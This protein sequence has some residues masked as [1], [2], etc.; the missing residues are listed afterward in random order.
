[1]KKKAQPSSA[2]MAASTDPV[3]GSSRTP[4]DVV[5]ESGWDEIKLPYFIGSGRTLASGV[6]GRLRIKFF[7]RRSDQHLV[8][9]VWFGDGADGPP[10]HAHGGAVAYVLDEAMGAVGWSVGYA[11][12]ASDLRFQYMAM[13]PLYQDL[14]VEAWVEADKGKQIEIRSNLFLADGTLA[15][16]GTGHFHKLS[17]KKL[18]GF[19]QSLP[20]DERA[21]HEPLM[22]RCLEKKP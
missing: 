6:E 8:G 1:M 20:P 9:R 2:S 16:S 7:F 17:P 14:A 21:L 18:E 22:R 19:L 13:T 3:A 5:P 15:V 10:R 12:V 4:P 11:T